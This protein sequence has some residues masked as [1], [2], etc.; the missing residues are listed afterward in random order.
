MDN[1]A[2]F[3]ADADA[4]AGVRI[5]APSRASSR[6][7]DD[8]RVDKGGIT[9]LEQYDSTEESPLLGDGSSSHY[10]SVSTFG[11]GE[12]AVPAWQGMR[13]FNGL[14]WW[15]K[16]SVYWLLPPFLLFTLAFGGIIVPKLNLILTLICREYMAEASRTDPQFSLLPVVFGDDNPQCRI[17]EV[18]KRVAQFTLYGSLISG[19]L[20]AI[21]SPYL[22]AL[23]DRHG[24]KPILI[25]TTLGML[26]GEVVTIFT[27]TFP[28]TISVNWILL[29]MAMDGLTGSFIVGMAVAHS[30]ATDCTAPQLRN[31]AFGY[32]HG[33]LFTG[34]ALGPIISGYIIKG[35]GSVLSAFYIALGCHAAFILF[36]LIF[37]P[38]S[39]SKARQ[40]V[41]QEKHRIEVE[42]LGPAAD[43][44]NQIRSYTL[45]EPLKI[46]YP[47]GEGSSG[48]IRRNLML[49]ASVDLIMFSVAM[50][51]MT[52]VV[53]YTNIEFGW[54]NLE[55][56]KFVSI[57]NSCRV[58]SL[59]VLLP[60]VT[61]L[62]RG[63]T[64]TSKQRNTGSDKFDLYVIRVAV[65]FDMAGFLGYTLARSG[66][67]FI[68]SG[69][70]ASAGGIGSPTLGSALTKHVPPDR[71]GQL[72]G[73][74]GLLHALGRILGPVIF[75]AIYGATVGKF[76]QTVFICL[77]AT[78]GLAFICSLF[79]RPHVYLDEPEF[80]A[81]APTAD[82]SEE[83]SVPH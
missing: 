20:S 19:L 41:A 32:F 4:E 8:D 5:G 50:G 36:L 22:G 25:L 78:F 45:V 38:E 16:P 23:S 74:V 1:E 48:A 35:T 40:T 53:Y 21:T 55:T 71:T 13:D 65:L 67:A 24:R 7:R 30:Y 83:E 81:S 66:G 3:T 18:Q 34:I 52:I 72:L 12:H 6:Y 73:A 39:L 11:D 26:V 80:P 42:R 17:P 59:I 76:R 61:R 14:P 68:L 10:G 56:S 49:L 28:D 46:L 31:V 37:I 47:T 75:N 62:V 2:V 51:A 9:N 15:K 58:I 82:E 29:G 43:W 33:C 70:L 44:I 63:S 64:G 57:V 27:A 77:T 60:I 79:I 54:G 69:A